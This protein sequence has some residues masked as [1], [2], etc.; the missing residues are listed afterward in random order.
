MVLVSVA[1]AVNFLSEKERSYAQA[2]EY[3]A[4]SDYFNAEYVLRDLDWRDSGEL[5]RMCKYHLGLDYMEKGLYESALKNFREAGDYEDAPALAAQM[6]EKLN[7]REAGKEETP[8]EQDQTSLSDT[9]SDESG[10][11]AHDKAASPHSDGKTIETPYYTVDLGEIFSD[12]EL[13]DVTYEYA[14]GYAFQTPG[15][16]GMGYEVSVRNAERPLFQIGCF[17]ED[18]GPQ[19]DYETMVMGWVKS[20]DYGI[21]SVYLC[22][23]HDYDAPEGTDLA[24][25]AA[26][27]LN[28]YMK[29]V[30]VTGP[31]VPEGDY[32]LPESDSRKYSKSELAGLSNWELY[33]ARNEIFA[34]HG[35]GFKS[36]DLVTYFNAKSWYS[37]LMAPE[38]FDEVFSP[39]KYE[40]ANT[41][42]I[43]ELER[44]GNS[45]HLN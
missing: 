6:E 44:D 29:G 32:I 17:S 25:R 41:D 5:R 19:G 9:S 36:E 43:M 16:M 45:P 33:V 8:E 20:P 7:E 22:V 35:R 28:R 2:Q 40:K 30:S 27:E 15:A 24:R 37:E 1:L 13:D 3:I 4:Q 38:D 39:N 31:K 12:S 18:W 10:G 26:D 14:D 42:L 34:R 11:E 21:M 23:P